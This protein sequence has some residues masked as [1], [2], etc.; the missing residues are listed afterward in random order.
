MMARLNK[1]IMRLGY[2]RAASEMDRQGYTDLATDLRTQAKD[3]DNA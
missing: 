2:L 3:L 1:Y